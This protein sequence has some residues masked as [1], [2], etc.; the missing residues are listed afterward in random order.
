LSKTPKWPPGCEINRDDLAHLQKLHHLL[1]ALNDPLVSRS[2]LAMLTASIPVFANRIVH[3]AKARWPSIDSLANALQR[4]GNRGLEQILLEFLE[5]LTMYK[6]DVEAAEN[7][8]SDDGASE[9]TKPV[10]EETKPV[11]EG[12]KISSG[13]TKK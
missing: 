2:K 12:T 5:D 4:I 11:A 8:A 13:S 10:A 1:N 3:H 7:P 6:A 9:G